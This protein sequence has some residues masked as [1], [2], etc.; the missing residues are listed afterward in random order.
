ME[1]ITAREAFDKGLKRYYTGLSCKF[2]HTAERMI[3]NGSCVACLKDRRDRTREKNY[4][5]VKEWRKKNPELRAAQ[6]KRYQE[7]HKD[8][9]NLYQKEYKKKNIEHVR[10]L[11]RENH[12][13]MRVLNPE[14]EKERIRRFSQRLEQK[15]IIEA[16]REKPELC[17]ICFTNEYRI[18]FDHCHNSGKFRG[19]ICDRCNRVLGIVKDS[20]KLLNDLAIYLENNNG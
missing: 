3:S 20:P 4:E 19:W 8:K 13:R 14:K 18:V 15:R 12:K 6:C 5:K 17:E 11:D 10:K 7:K 1:K 2:G 16:G 9:L